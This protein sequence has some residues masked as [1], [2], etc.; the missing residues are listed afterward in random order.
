MENS[1]KQNAKYLG[2]L[3]ERDMQDPLFSLIRKAAELPDEAMG[4]EQD[5]KTRETARR[6]VREHAE[7]IKYFIATETGITDIDTPPSDN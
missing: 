5:F 6:H 7:E 2:E 4:S 3:V 1:G